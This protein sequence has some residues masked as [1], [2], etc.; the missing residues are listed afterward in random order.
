MLWNFRSKFSSYKN[1]N[2][3][4]NQQYINGNIMFIYQALQSLNIWFENFLISKFKITE[5]IKE[6]SK[7]EKD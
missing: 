3:S 6:L 5:L 4:T 1:Y 7:N 2:F